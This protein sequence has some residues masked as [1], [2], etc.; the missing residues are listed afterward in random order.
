MSSEIPDDIR[1][2]IR[3]NIGSVSLLEVLLLMKRKP[4][5]E[6]RAEEIS[7]EMRTNVSYA[8]SQLAELATAKLIVQGKNGGFEFPADS[9]KI[10]ILD[11]LDMLYSN[12]RSTLISFIYSQPIDNIRDFANAFKIKKD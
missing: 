9:I 7:S 6:W 3:R 8:S 11:R 1:D 12:R 5:K 4:N 10:E 2:F